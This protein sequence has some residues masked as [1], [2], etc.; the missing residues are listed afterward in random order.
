MPSIDSK[1]SINEYLQALT[2]SRKTWDLVRINKKSSHLGTIRTFCLKD[3]P[4][5][6]LVFF[7]VN[8][9]FTSASIISEEEQIRFG[10]KK[11]LNQR[12]LSLMRYS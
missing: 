10:L 2:Q 6:A 4:N 9:K 11:H 7:T 1:R 12:G 3:H 5:K 8:D